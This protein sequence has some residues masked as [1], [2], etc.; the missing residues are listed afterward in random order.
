MIF[1]Q[2][3]LEK[4]LGL[5]ITEDKDIHTTQSDH[6]P[7]R[8]S[9]FQRV[10]EDN[11]KCI[12]RREL[13]P[14]KTHQPKIIVSN[15]FLTIRAPHNETELALFN[16]ITQY[17]EVYFWPGK[18]CP[19]SQAKLIKSGIE[20][21]E[22]RD[23]LIPAF[24]S[25]VKKCLEL[26]GFDTNDFLIIDKA[27][28]Q[29]LWQKLNNEKET[30]PEIDIRTLKK[31]NLESLEKIM[32]GIDVTKPYHLYVHA[33]DEDYLKWLFNIISVP[34][35]ITL[36]MDWSCGTIG[37][38]NNVPAVSFN[39]DLIV[40]DSYWNI[41]LHNITQ[42]T[43]LTLDSCQ[44]IKVNI[45]LCNNLKSIDINDGSSQNS[46][47]TIYDNEQLSDLNISLRFDS[48]DFKNITIDY[49]PNI[50]KVSLYN[51]RNDFRHVNFGQKLS[52][53]TVTNNDYLTIDFINKYNNI[54]HLEIDS[55]R[56]I[57]SLAS[58]TLPMLENLRVTLETSDPVNIIIDQ[59]HFP[60]LKKF[61]LKIYSRDKTAHQNNIE[62]TN[63]AIEQLD[64]SQGNI[65]CNL[66]LNCQSLKILSLNNF[67]KLDQAILPNLKEL[68]INNANITEI[69]L[70]PK[71]KKLTIAHCSQLKKLDL[72]LLGNLHQLY[73]S[74]CTRLQE[75]ILPVAATLK[76][77]YIN[78]CKA[79]EKLENKVQPNLHFLHLKISDG[80]T[81]PLINLSD[82]PCLDVLSLRN[83]SVSDNDLCSLNNLE[84][85]ELSLAVGERFTVKNLP[86]LK[87]LEIFGGDI[88]LINLPQLE[89]LT[90]TTPLRLIDNC[91]NISQI[92][93]TGYTDSSPSVVP[94]LISNIQSLRIRCDLFAAFIQ[95]V[96]CRRLKWLSLY[97]SPQK[98][99]EITLPECL[100]E[101]EY[102]TFRN[103][104]QG[105]QSL[106]IKAGYL[107]HLKRV[108]TQF[109][110]NH[111][112]FDFSNCHQLK[113]VS[114]INKANE[115]CDVKINL[116]ESSIQ[117][118]KLQ[119]V[120]Q[121]LEKN[122]EH[123]ELIPGQPGKIFKGKRTIH[124]TASPVDRVL[125][126]ILPWRSLSIDQLTENEKSL[127][128]AN[129]ASPVSYFSLEK[130]V[131]VDSN[132][133]NN[134][135]VHSAAGQFRVEL[136]SA[137]GP[138]VKNYNRVEI[139]DVVQFDGNNEISFIASAHDLIEIHKKIPTFNA[140]DKTQFYH[141]LKTSL[142]N[143]EL[144][145]LGGNI[146]QGEDYPLV[147]QHPDVDPPDIFCNPANAIKLMYD[148]EAQQFRI[149][150]LTTTKIELIYF[151]KKN[152][153]YDSKANPQSEKLVVT[154]PSLLLPANLTSRLMIEL[155]SEY[156]DKDKLG[157]LFDN[158]IS[159]NE[160]M[161]KLVSYCQFDAIDLPQ[162]EAF[163]FNALIQCIKHRR[164][165]CSHN[166]A[167]FMVLARLIGVPVKYPCSRIHAYAEIPYLV[168][169]SKKIRWHRQDLGGGD[170]IDLTPS[171]VLDSKYAKLT[172]SPDIS[173]AKSDLN[174]LDRKYYSTA[175]PLIDDKTTYSS[176]DQALEEQYY[177]EL[178]QL[179]DKKE[180]HDLQ[181]LFNDHTLA[182][183][184]ELQSG[185]NAF[186]INKI[187]LQKAK[188]MD[189][190]H[191]YISKPQEF[192]LFLTPAQI[193]EGKVKKINGPLY[194][195]IKNGGVLVIDWSNFAA[196]DMGTFQKLLESNFT[197]AGIKAS[198]H[199]RVIGISDPATKAGSAFLSRCKRWYWHEE[200]LQFKPAVTEN[201][202]HDRTTELR[203]P[204]GNDLKADSAPLQSSNKTIPQQ[205]TKTIDSKDV[206]GNSTWREKL[207]GQITIA[208]KLK[209]LKEGPLI[210]AI[211]E[212]RPFI[213][214][215]PP[216]GNKD[217]DLLMY[218]LQIER[219]LIYN[220]EIL[221]IED[222]APITTATK[223][224]PDLPQFPIY[225]ESE[226]PDNK[227]STRRIYLNI[228]N[229]HECFERI[230][231]DSKTQEVT[232]SDEGLLA[233]Y[234]AG[235]I[236]YITG[237]IP[238]QDWDE[239]RATIKY[240]Y[241]DKKFEFVLAPGAA[242]AQVKANQ[243]SA[244]NIIMNNI[245]ELPDKINT[246]FSNDT[247]YVAELL[248]KQ[249]KQQNQQPYI[250]NVSPQTEF[251]ELIADIKILQSDQDEVNSDILYKEQGLLKALMETTPRSII[252]NGELS[253]SVYQQLLSLLDSPPSIY[254]NG[255]RI[256]KEI[257]GRLIIV[258]PTTAKI[259]VYALNSVQKDYTFKDYYA[260]FPNENLLLSRL[261]QF[262]HWA[263]KF[264]HQGIGVPRQTE[265]S[266]H[267]LQNMLFA[268]KTRKLHPHNPIK[269]LYHYD[270]PNR[271]YLNVIAKYNLCPDDESLPRKEKLKSLIINNFIKLESA[272]DLE[273]YVWEILNCYNGA[274][275]LEILG[276][277]LAQSLDIKSAPPTLT[278]QTL[279]LLFERVNKDYQLDISPK[280]PQVDK[281]KKELHTLLFEKKCKLIVL[282]G[283]PAAGKTFTADALKKNSNVV[284]CRGK[285]KIRKWLSDKSQKKKVLFL[286]E[287][288]LEEE[289][290]WDFLK[291]ISLNDNVIYFEGEFFELTEDHVIL[292]AGNPETFPQRA[293]H[294]F[295]QR[296]AE[297]IYVAETTHEY[298]K[299]N[300]IEPLLAEHQLQHYAQRLLG[301]YYLIAE[302]NPQY[303]YTLRDAM[304]LTQRF[305]CLV[306]NKVYGNDTDQNFLHACI[307]EFA[308][309]IEIPVQ[310]QRFCDELSTRFGIKLEKKS[311]K[312]PVI[313]INPEHVITQQKNY[314][315]EAIEQDLL[316]ME[317]M[318][319]KA[320][321]KR[322]QKE[323]FSK[324]Q[325]EP[326]L[327]P[328]TKSSAHDQKDDQS[329]TEKNTDYFKQCIVIE[330]DPGVGK[331]SIIRALIQR[332]NIPF[333][334]IEVGSKDAHQRII[335]AYKNN[336]KIILDE[337]NL[338]DSLE[339]LL[340]KLLKKNN[341]YFMVFA[342]QNNSSLVG[343][344]PL[345]KAMRNRT[346]FLYMDKYSNDEMGLLAEKYQLKATP[347][348]HALDRI[349]RDFPN[350]VNDR[351]TFT[352]MKKHSRVANIHHRPRRAG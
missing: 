304:N 77:L 176:A 347:F 280:V 110:T 331:S 253:Y 292:A 174:I 8:I 125:N 3:A 265:L 288:N 319:T 328:A 296:H 88:A 64:I 323:A 196:S 295:F 165:V 18:N 178:K 113:I 155:K 1:T 43:S 139:F 166:T 153:E 118:F 210:T 130:K 161:D 137:Q 193:S 269:G 53:L 274:Q 79:L 220:G 267:L 157:F 108:E 312:P 299:H 54:T 336:K 250:I 348:M 89:K 14:Q 160:K 28:H 116:D 50:S 232:T 294:A 177:Q 317:M 120:D 124:H 32:A 334:D 149:K 213:I 111:I 192:E 144:V 45:C 305:N 117:S 185:Q 219:K 184:I 290:T 112:D 13:I 24:E 56:L 70:F 300:I 204:A 252:L 330:G 102:F 188:E 87:Q 173:T 238:Q 152:R 251:S 221:D 214:E 277:D 314:I 136:H 233:Q 327:E 72:V 247:D 145:D 207:L 15:P 47:L 337:F 342:S 230:I 276:K 175:T 206:F 275:L 127:S 346:H 182:P 63:N 29:K 189:V 172:S 270:Y 81:S 20:F 49:C 66:K 97:E 52:S 231:I 351:T 148:E 119:G 133:G 44:L 282:K 10:L 222:N 60:K 91:P 349:C 156:A 167:A 171:G 262:Y 21:W 61:N 39:H 27:F 311:N 261:E 109:W 180:L 197:L 216:I 205:E 122:I 40:L 107:P 159:I 105:C 198:P 9:L 138:V 94:S 30:I 106:K 59:L 306:T 201:E 227:L 284:F 42:L 309:T 203:P 68:S 229:F 297:T 259:K 195:L 345:S 208:K 343:R 150:A 100:K 23:T 333:E 17:F 85:L 325:A 340:I 283:M 316:L 272:T 202:Q 96:D 35:K 5:E 135:V 209:T 16:G 350:S 123:F 224:H 33:H 65:I 101:L 321:Q 99:I 93:F 31:G 48:L 341:P 46:L 142:I 151:V 320:E 194:N 179:I 242:I 90:Y 266:Y 215:N 183:L 287:F 273:S 163:S 352:M 154:D 322:N 12:E 6:G 58:L 126:K 169:P 338:D 318:K 268:M 147:S 245:A 84:T 308:G 98:T 187:I 162:K 38:I 76:W 80:G 237:K 291:G 19:F 78:D 158:A 128:D 69:D 140:S 129:E 344:K 313:E 293:H 22:K 103:V 235:D 170:L 225:H 236:F 114:I 73:T 181:P 239:L 143:C 132:T 92:N 164:G 332:K 75:L 212:K 34:K 104:N 243:Q 191:I 190:Q 200:K 2:I 26:Q 134:H 55:C 7:G 263:D 115:R 246:I 168:Y 315:V 218:R 241:P 186:D 37:H 82:Y 74:D 258:M 256:D 217:F 83:Y 324:Q 234:R 302:F 279:Q 310:R 254:T 57:T 228:L 301:A 226:L 255:N 289:G 257:T 240:K 335:D 223:A 211:R 326:K 244:N 199:L 51:V 285:E 271:T 339:K 86:K 36:V 71:L 25:D 4:L 11:V 121:R 41:Y 286:D 131:G 146:I 307:G 62:I 260:A 141:S 249:C 95:Q 303:I 67:D 278:K 298:V 329:T 281:A 264:P 248:A